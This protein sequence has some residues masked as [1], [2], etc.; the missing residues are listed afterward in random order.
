MSSGTGSQAS[1]GSSS[2]GLSLSPPDSGAKYRR[3][4]SLATSGQARTSSGTSKTTIVRRCGTS[5]AGVAPARVPIADAHAPAAFTT[6]RVGISPSSVNTA[7]ARPPATRTP[8]TVTPKRCTTPRR[9][10]WPR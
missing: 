6:Q 3:F 2:I 7:C 8:R 1:I 9:R 10:A 5:A 4:S